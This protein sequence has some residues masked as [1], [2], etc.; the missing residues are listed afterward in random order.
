VVQE[1]AD[2]LGVTMPEAYSVSSF[3]KEEGDDSLMQIDED[4]VS[5][6]EPLIEGVQEPQPLLHGFTGITQLGESSDN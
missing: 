5:L 6:S 3:S 1:V 4:Q 2:G